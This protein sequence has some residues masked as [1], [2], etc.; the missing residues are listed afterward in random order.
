[1]KFTRKTR[2]HFV[3]LIGISMHLTECISGH[4][5]WTEEPHP[6]SLRLSY[7][8]AILFLPDKPLITIVIMIENGRGRERGST[9][10]TRAR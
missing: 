6:L 9:L 5:C 3:T 4:N 10:S 7:S 8:A 2:G 1:M